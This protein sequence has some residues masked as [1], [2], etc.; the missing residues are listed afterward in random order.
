MYLQKD[1]RT[2][3]ERKRRHDQEQALNSALIEKK[4]TEQ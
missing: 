1:E 4:R 3:L 2:E